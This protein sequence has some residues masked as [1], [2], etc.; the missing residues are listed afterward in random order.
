MADDQ[1]LI[2]RRVFTDKNELLREGLVPLSIPNKREALMAYWQENDAATAAEEAAAAQ[3][4]LDRIAALEQTPPE[5]SGAMALTALQIQADELAAQVSQLQGLAMAT[6]DEVLRGA[7]QIS[8]VAGLAAEIEAAATA[9]ISQV[10]G[11][12]AGAQARLAELDGQLATVVATAGQ[13]VTDCRQMVDSTNAMMLAKTTEAISKRITGLEVQ[14]AQLR[15]PKGHT[16]NPG[17]STV[18]GA[19]RPQGPDV[20]LPLIERPAIKGDVYIDGADDSR[21]AYRWTGETWEPGPAMATIQVRDVKVSAM[22]MSTKSTTMVQNTIAGGSGGGAETLK[23]R[24]VGNGLNNFQELASMDRW[25]AN[26]GEPAHTVLVSVEAVA[27]DGPESGR[28]FTWLKQLHRHAQTGQ[29]E[30]TDFA[31]VGELQTYVIDLSLNMR[32]FVQPPS[33]TG[34]MPPLMSVALMFRSITRTDGA[35]VGSSRWALK[36]WC[37]WNMSS[38]TAK[39]SPAWKLEDEL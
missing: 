29:T 8:R 1:Q 15:G 19:G 22:D 3:A 31:C 7:S 24:I 35:A 30:S 37:Q 33:I 28:S 39:L 10:D 38:T 4:E 16:G 9:A 26:G 32:N 14:A 23:T 5:V 11:V 17:V 36:G 20:L 2:K 18:V 13:V 12:S 27:L 34:T 25:C 6:P 21:R